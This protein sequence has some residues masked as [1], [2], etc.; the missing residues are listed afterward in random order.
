M[1]R[2]LALR[3]AALLSAQPAPDAVRMA[4]VSEEDECPCCLTHSCP[5]FRRYVASVLAERAHL[6]T[7]AMRSALRSD[8]R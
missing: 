1:S 3:L 7:G 8:G 5:A 6:G 4:T 2:R